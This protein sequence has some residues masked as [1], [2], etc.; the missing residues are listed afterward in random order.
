MNS[1]CY[2]L[3]AVAIA[4]RS[5]IEAAP[6]NTTTSTVPFTTTQLPAPV[7]SVSSVSTTEAQLTTSQKIETT[8]KKIYD[9]SP[10]KGLYPSP[11]SCSQYYVCV[12][13]YIPAYV[14]DCPANLW[15]DASLQ[16]CN[17]PQL[18][19]CELINIRRPSSFIV[20]INTQNATT[21][22]PSTIETTTS[23]STTSSKPITA[24]EVPT[25]PTD[26]PVTATS[27]KVETTTKRAY[28]CSNGLGQYPSPY[29]CSQY[30]VCV[31]TYIPA[32]VFDCPANLWYDPKLEQCNYQQLVD[33]DITN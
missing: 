18:V 13:P 7:S 33:C 27:E 17:Y 11:Y 6:T 16:Q 3:L 2:G 12:Q 14:F 29:S 9:C 21:E 24:T 5:C 25:T 23:N 19:D 8:T 15:F 20:K 22:D 1:L 32:Y 31:Q 26:I 4:L 30:Y 10:G 28:D